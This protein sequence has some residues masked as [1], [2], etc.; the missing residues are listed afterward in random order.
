MR[1][2]KTYLFMQEYRLAFKSTSWNLSRASAPVFAD[3]A[4]LQAAGLLPAVYELGS[5]AATSRFFGTRFAGP[6]EATVYELGLKTRFERG[7]FNLAIFEQSIEGFQSNLFQGSG[8]VL[9][10]AGEQSTEGFEVDAVWLPVDQL[11]LTFAAT[12]L[13]A[14]YDQFENAP[15]PNNSVIDLSGEEPAGIPEW[16]ISS[17]VTYNFELG[18]AAAFVRADWQYESNVLMVDNILSSTGAEQ[19]FREISTVNASSG[20]SWEMGFQFNSGPETYLTMNICF[21]PF[22][23][24]CNR[25]SST[26]IA[27]CRER[28]ASVFERVSRKGGFTQQGRI[29]FS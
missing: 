3:G 12:Y 21:R 25:A 26:D 22:R 2:V 4:A 27:T 24:Y 17:S 23:V 28:M 10:N 6:E 29:S 18:S 16:S 20:L 9:A 8:F 14:V 19:P 13:D 7:A 1:R 5:S 15:G 11:R